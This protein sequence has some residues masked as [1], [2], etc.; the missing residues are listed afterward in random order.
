MDFLVSVH[1]ETQQLF[2]SYIKF[3]KYEFVPNESHNNMLNFTFL[4]EI[5]TEKYE[6]S[7]NVYL[8]NLYI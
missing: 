4:S 6:N 2:A 5:M 7:G 8:I 3:I 1:F